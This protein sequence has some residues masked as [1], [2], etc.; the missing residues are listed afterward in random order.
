M[1]PVLG[2]SVLIQ[3][4]M[5]HLIIRNIG[6]IK[7]VD[8]ELNKINV[9][10]GPQSSGK[11]TINK[12]ACYC[13]WVEK[14]IAIDNSFEYFIGEDFFINDLVQYHK[15][16]GYIKQNSYIEYE[17]EVLKLT[18]THSIR[19]LNIEWKDRY[20]FKRPKITYIPSERNMVSVIPNWFEVKLKDSYFLDFLADWST[21]RSHLSM[22]NS[23]EILNLGVK[24]YFDELTKKDYVKVDNETT[25]ELT[26][27][28]SGLQSIIPLIILVNYLTNWV[29]AAESLTSVVDKQMNNQLRITKEFFDVFKD[30][31][32]K[33]EN[34]AIQFQLLGEKIDLSNILNNPKLVEELN[35]KQQEF[36]KNSWTNFFIEEPEQNLFPSSQRDL[37]YFLLQTI[38]GNK[39]HKLFLTTHSPYILYALNNCMLGHLVKDNMPEDEAKEL[40]CYPAWIDPQKVSVWEIEDGRLRNIQD[41]DNIVSENY[42]DQQMTKLTNEYYQ[43]LNYYE[44]E[45]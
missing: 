40:L 10:M 15:L 20:S 23:S 19:K 21:A 42:F 29:Y 38:N 27:T 4:D 34:K 18:Y 11:S 33:N 16:N 39:D 24:Y 37:M 36:Y 12:I 6:P 7:E 44:D 41:K 35:K 2:K 13:S 25:L 22:E 28:S 1:A 32:N 26:N 45:E 3:K 8:I 14:K 5:A 31:L 9:I 17:S 43:M 30:Y